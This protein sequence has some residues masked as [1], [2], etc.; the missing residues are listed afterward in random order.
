MKL[1]PSQSIL[2]KHPHKPSSFSEDLRQG[3]VVSNC[4][5]E[6]M[7]CPQHGVGVGII[8]R[9]KGKFGTPV[10]LMSFHKCAAFCITE[11]T[12]S[13]TVLLPQPIWLR[14]LKSF[15]CKRKCFCYTEPN[16]TDVIWSPS[17]VFIIRRF[18][19]YLIVCWELVSLVNTV[20]LNF[21][22]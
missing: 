18:I 16:Y 13:Y 11:Q 9:E 14:C 19:F 21:I 10:K 1:K 12:R 20:I 5:Y 3:K 8:K 15:L 17:V 7:P 4:S 6:C 22:I 2:L